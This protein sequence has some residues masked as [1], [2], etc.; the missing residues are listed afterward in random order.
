MHAGDCDLRMWLLRGLPLHCTGG[1]C[2]ITHTNGMRGQCRPRLHNV[3]V[4]TGRQVG[5]IGLL[6][7]RCVASSALQLCQINCQLLQ[8]RSP[9]PWPPHTLPVLCCAV[10]A[11][12]GC[13]CRLFDKLHLMA[14]A[15]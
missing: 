2:L 12:C 1:S 15:N 13:L 14:A 3:A 7:A 5:A 6:L 9:A 8:P 11:L 10:C 4:K